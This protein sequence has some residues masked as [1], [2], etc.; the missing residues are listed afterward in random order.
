MSVETTSLPQSDPLQSVADALDAAVHAARGG[1]EAAQSAATDAFPVVGGILSS[2]T[3]KACYGLAYGVVFPTMLVV[4]A[5]PKENAVVHGF[6]DG[7][8]AAIDMVDEMRSG[9]RTPQHP[10]PAP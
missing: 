8:R 1:A 5:V 6:V 7:A 2:M 10:S 4:K 9:A 3:Y